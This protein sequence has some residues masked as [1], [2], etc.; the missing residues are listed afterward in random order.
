MT[1]KSGTSTL[2]GAVYEFVRNAAMD[3][4][5]FLAADKQTLRQNQYGWALGCLIV[6]PRDHPEGKSSNPDFVTA[7]IWAVKEEKA[8]K[9]V[10]SSTFTHFTF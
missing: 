8:I 2:H 4:R 9:P 7:F 1:T 3:S 6:K 10:V 5:Q